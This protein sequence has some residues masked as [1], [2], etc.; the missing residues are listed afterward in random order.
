MKIKT[1]ELTGAAL[2]WAV[3]KCEGREDPIYRFAPDQKDEDFDPEK[4]YSKYFYISGPD[5]QGP[6]EPSTNDA[7]GSPIIGREGIQLHVNEGRT[8]WL[9]SRWGYPEQQYGPTHLV[10]AMRCYVASELG[11]EVEI[12]EELA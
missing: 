1:S 12:P 2:D 8:E 9:A 7:Q 5:R 6:Y 10:A 11:D 4:D 3:A